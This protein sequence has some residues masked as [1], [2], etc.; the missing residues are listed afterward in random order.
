M[1]TIAAVQ[2]DLSIQQLG[3]ITQS[4]LSLSMTPRALYP[5]LHGTRR[6]E[7]ALEISIWT[8]SMETRLVAVLLIRYIGRTGW[9]LL[10]LGEKST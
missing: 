2:G 1:L 7:N 3:Q 8:V 4:W 9:S 5:S 6:L 10:F